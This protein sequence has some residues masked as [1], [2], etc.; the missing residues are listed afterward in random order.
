VWVFDPAGFPK[1]GTASVGGAR[2][3][4]GRLGKVD[5]GQVAVSL[6][7]VSGAGP[8]LV[9]MRLSWPKAWTTDKARLDKAGVPHAQRGYRARHPWALDLWQTRGTQLPHGWSAGDDEMGR[10]YWFRRRLDRLGERSRRAVPGHTLRRDLETAPAASS[11]RR[12]PPTPPGQRVE[13]W[14]ASLDAGAWKRIDVR[15]GST[16]PLVVD[17]VKRRVGARTPRRPQGDEEL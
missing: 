12:R 17:V 16:G 1:S 10:P 7:S 2:Q 6:G 14:S 9:A 11:G 8:T 15:D 13:A 4:W 3:W 5:N